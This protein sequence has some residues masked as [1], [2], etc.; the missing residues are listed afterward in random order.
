MTGRGGQGLIA[1]T[2][3]GGA[4]RANFDQIHA[5]SGVRGEQAGFTMVELMMS[6]IVAAILVSLAVP[7]FTGVINS[8]RLT[9]PANELLAGL[10]GARATA[11]SRNTR[12]VLC[13]SDDGATCSTAGGNWP[14]WIAF[15]DWNGDFA[16]DNAG[17]NLIGSGTIAAPATL[18]ASSNAT[19][20]R[21]VFRSD[22]MARNSDN[23]LMNVALRV[24]IQ[25]RFPAEN[26]RDVRLLS[27]GRTSVVASNGSKA[28]AAPGNPTP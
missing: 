4:M 5:A 8:N 22:G 14:G 11:I 28:C 17:D 23:T 24:C 25:T 6:I 20:S 16:P 12:V 19:N 10:Q 1:G 13:R 2:T 7:S 18:Q 9:G 26:I 15:V 3:M 21:L 27:G